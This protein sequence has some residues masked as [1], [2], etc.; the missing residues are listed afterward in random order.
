MEAL[1]HLAGAAP[2]LPQAGV[3]A[4]LDRVLAVERRHWSKLLGPLDEAREDDLRRGL[5]QV[6]AV[7]GVPARRAAQDL[8]MRDR[9]YKREVPNDVRTVVT[10]LGRVYATPTGGIA[11]L[12]PDLIGEHEVATT[13][14]DELIGGCLDWIETLPEAEREPGRRRLLTVL[15]RATRPEHGAERCAEAEARIA[16]IIGDHGTALAP[17]IVAVM[18]E[19]PGA[20]KVV[21]ERMLDRLDLAALSAFDFA[22]PLM[23]LQLLELALAVSQRHVEAAKEHLARADAHSGEPGASEAALRATAAAVGQYGNRLSNLGRREEA[24]TAAEEA[25]AILR[26]L[27]EA[28]PDAFLPDL[29]RSLSVMADCFEGLEETEQALSANHEAVEILSPYFLAHPQAFASLMDW[30]VQGYLRRCESAGQ[31]P[32]VDLVMPIV[33]VF[34]ALSEQQDT[35]SAGRDQPGI[36][37]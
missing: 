16:A 18:T 6:T 22:L 15:Q 32:D 27:A 24:L 13:A 12:E 33:E 2:A 5:S 23:H 9:F 3:E 4:L 29:A 30:I 31:Q 17:D 21:F 34:Q 8:L 1:L 20:M 28:R 10:D 25:V 11:P 37:G 7:G 19:T 14:D 35:N 36:S 26:R